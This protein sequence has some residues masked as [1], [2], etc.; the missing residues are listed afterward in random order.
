[1]VLL[2]GSLHDGPMQEVKEELER[3]DAPVLVVNQ[4]NILH[5][6]MHLDLASNKSLIEYCN[7]RFDCNDIQSAYIRTYD[8]TKV[9]NFQSIDFNDPT[10]QKAVQFE[11][12]MITMLEH[13]PGTIVN[14]IS[15]AYSNCSKPYQMD[16]IKNFGFEVPDTI[17]TTSPEYAKEFLRKH[18]RIIYKSIS[19]CRSIVSCLTM[20]DIERLN[21]VVWC[22]TQFQNY[23]EGVDYRVHV[24]GEKIFTTKIISS[25]SDFRYAKDTQLI[26]YKLPVEVAESC[27]KLTK[28]LGLHF[29]G[30]DLRCSS[31]NQWYCF[32]V[33]PSP[34]YTYFSTGTGQNITTELIEYL[35]LS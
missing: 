35:L 10:F 25:A 5:S 33:N 22:P 2:W 21:D 23:V 12:Q 11:Q 29:S 6:A 17:I 9:C 13:H 30:I 7:E 4:K 18:E 15:K 27:F 14:R 16:I 28:H 26:N 24:L 3:L 20:K 19:S 1:M 8:F 31:D 32:E 34:G